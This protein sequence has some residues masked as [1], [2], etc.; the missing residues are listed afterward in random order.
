MLKQELEE[1]Q[2]RKAKE[3]EETGTEW[4]PRFFVGAVTPLGKPELTDE[5]KEALRKLQAGDWELKESLVLGA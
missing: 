3:R 1:G 2:R 5:G 4:Q